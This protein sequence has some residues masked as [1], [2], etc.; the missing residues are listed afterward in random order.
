MFKFMLS[1]GLIITVILLIINCIGFSFLFA[2]NN[3]ILKDN[4]GFNYSKIIARSNDS[5]DLTLPKQI[6]IY[7]WKD[8]DWVNSAK[9]LF[10]YDSLGRNIEKFYQKWSYDQWINSMRWTYKFN[11][12]GLLYEE[13]SER[14]E[15]DSWIFS[16]RITNYYYDN[17][18]LKK[19]LSRTWVDSE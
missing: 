5:I 10:I 7:N 11:D 19:K 14:W 2:G 18:K 9:W 15:N 4:H 8:S 6:I 3:L 12:N 17:Q 13:I 16:D 1:K